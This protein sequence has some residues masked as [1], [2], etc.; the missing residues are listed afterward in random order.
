MPSRRI[1]RGR[2]ALGKSCLQLGGAEKDAFCLVE[3]EIAKAENK[4]SDLERFIQR[5]NKYINLKEINAYVVRELIS[6]IY[7]EAPDRSSG[8]RVQRI[9]IKYDLVGYIPVDEMIE[10]KM[11]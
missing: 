4:I 5:V 6:A 3:E 10:A 7:V 8:H 11:A 2:S 1:Q 9:H